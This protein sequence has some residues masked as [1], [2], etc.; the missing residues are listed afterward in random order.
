MFEGNQKYLNPRGIAKPLFNL[1]RLTGLPAESTV[2]ICE[3]VPDALAMEAHGLNAVGVLGAT[4]FQS[5]W[6]DPFLKFNVEVLAQGDAAGKK[7]V[8]DISLFFRTRGKSVSCKCLP[9][10]KDAADVFA[11]GEKI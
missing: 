1:D 2:H 10:G 3:G 4:S 9:E 8:T 6:A 7:F 11:A 5:E